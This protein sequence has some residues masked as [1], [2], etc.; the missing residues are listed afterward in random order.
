MY[1]A[2]FAIPHLSNSSG[3]PTNAIYGFTTML[4]KIISEYKPDYLAMVFDTP[5]PTFRHE[6]YEDYKANRPE[7]PDTL[8]A[9]IPYI[10]EVVKGYNIALLEKEGFEADDIIGTIAKKEETKDLEIV[11]ASGDK[12]LLQLVNE[13]ITV[14]DTM[15]DKRFDKKG[16][17]D[18]LG[19]EPRKVTDFLG[20]VGD[21]SDNVPGVP[22]IGKKTAL[23]LLE[24]HDT[25]HDL[26]KHPESITSKKVKENLITCADQALLSK[27]LVTLDTEVPIEYDLEELKATDPDRE[28]LKDIF[29]E[30]EFTK[31]LQGLTTQDSNVLHAEYHLVSTKES[32]VALLSRLQDAQVCAVSLIT[33]TSDPLTSKPSGIAFATSTEQAFYVPLTD[34][35]PVD[36]SF[37]REWVMNH[38]KPLME[39]EGMKKYGHNIKQEI[40]AFKQYRVTLR[41]IACDTMI[42]SY[43]LNPSR[44]SHTLE[45][46]A[47]EYFD[48]K[49]KLYKELVGSGKKEIPFDQV[50]TEQAMNYAC[51]RALLVL[52]AT[53][54]LKQ[55]L[56]WEGFDQLFYQVEL[57]LLTV[58]ATMEM[59]G[60]KIDTDRLHAISQEFQDV[61][62]TFSEKI[63]QLAGET[64]NINS[65]QQLGKILFEKLQLPGA[66]KTKTGFSTDVAVLTK[67]AQ[68][69]PLPAEVLGYRSI[70]KLKSTYVDA[71]PHLVN[72]VTGRIHTS[73]NQTVTATG[74]LSSSNPNLQ[75]IPIRT[76][77]GR[78]IR[79]AF[80]AETGCAILAADYSQIELRILAHLSQDTLLLESFKQNED[81]HT[82][83]AAEIFG[84]MP[85]LVTQ[86]MRR[87]AKVI[88]F[89]IIYGMSSFGLAKELGISPKA[90]GAFIENYFQKYKGVKN[91]LDML[92]KEAQKQHYVTTLMK[93][94]RYIPEINSKNLTVRQFAER[95][96]IN[97]PIQGT[98]AD[99][100]KVAMLSISNRLAKEKL[101]TKMIMQVHDELVFEV[102]EK[103]LET[104][105][106]IVKEAMENVMELTIPLKVE[107]HW[108]KTWNE[109]H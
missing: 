41:G 26:L 85:N 61:L 102:P 106:L 98:A 4:Q 70:S 35:P 108:G 19:I 55:Q 42:A 94:R 13:H 10:K 60:V 49:M 57:P 24:Q 18:Y 75:N 93:R 25:I 65:P 32:F 17:I 64:F 103:E 43:L 58:L 44:H 40:I 20:L 107:I 34:T 72:P 6:V 86:Q 12:D 52:K 105:S 15:K 84:L 76:A 22:G 81:I 3:V 91:Y 78:K 16:V 56:S 8:S 68:N 87:E 14:I 50:E 92:L 80:I 109:A 23:K 53:T 82:R 2:F 5:A 71:L 83:T 30:L 38:I 11:I 100:I 96:A 79:E 47:L 39:D 74:R 29:K 37:T 21:S 27:Q 77:E 99:L 62:S 7:M 104:V 73:Y 51:E 36:T 95:T 63:Y 67:L 45:E 54:R 46:I 66:K 48:H 31:L 28:K 101:K 33:A 97:A 1:R 59:S 69:H 90:A 88:N 89:G 9:Q